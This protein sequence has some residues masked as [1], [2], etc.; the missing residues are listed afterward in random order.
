ML[1]LQQESVDKITFLLEYFFSKIFFY[2]KRMLYIYLLKH[3]TM[4]EE[5]NEM[6]KNFQ[7]MAAKLKEMVAQL[8]AVA[9]STQVIET[10]HCRFIIHLN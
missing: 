8:K 7:E 3:K 5:T 4:S 6:E 9:D 2:L 10:E 1:L